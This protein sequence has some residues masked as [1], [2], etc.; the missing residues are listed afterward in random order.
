MPG[1]GGGFLVIQAGGSVSWKYHNQYDERMAQGIGQW[2]PWEQAPED[3]RQAAA[4]GQTESLSP[5][6]T[7]EGARGNDPNQPVPGQGTGSGPNMPPQNQSTNM[8]AD[9]NDPFGTGVGG[10]G[11]D[12]GDFWGWAARNAEHLAKGLAVAIGIYMQHKAQGKADERA[13]RQEERS[14]ALGDR[15]IAL[16]ER[17]YDETGPLRQA[18]MGNALGPMPTPPNLSEVFADQGNPFAA[19]MSPV[20][21]SGLQGAPFGAPEWG[22]PVGSMTDPTGGGGSPGGAPDDGGTARRRPPPPAAPPGGVGGGDPQRDPRGDAPLAIQGFSPD[23]RDPF[24]RLPPRMRPEDFGR[25][26]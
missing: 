13:D 4:S 2:V 19:A 25:R 21:L 1:P 5:N 6:P 11:I 15:A 24:R 7:F 3:W 26:F 22:M 9:P 8:P 10:G 14:N 17:Q 18:F 12:W 23:Q 20:T 16:A